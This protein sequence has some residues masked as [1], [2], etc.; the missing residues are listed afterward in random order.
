[1]DKW[2]CSCGQ[3]NTSNFCSSCGKPKPEN[4]PTLDVTTTTPFDSSPIQPVGENTPMLRKWGSSVLMLIF[5]IATSVY[6]LFTVVTLFMNLHNIIVIG[7]SVVNILIG[8]LVCAGAWKIFANAKKQDLPLQSGGHRML[9][10]CFVY[11]EVILTL[12]LAM[13]ILASFMLVAASSVIEQYSGELLQ[14]LQESGMDTTIVENIMALGTTIF[15]VLLIVAIV[16]FVITIIAFTFIRKDMRD[17]IN[18]IDNPS[19]RGVSSLKGTVFMF[20][21]AALTLIV[22]I[23]NIVIHADVMSILT[24]LVQTALFVLGG[25]LLLNFNKTREA[26][27]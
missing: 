15:V 23:L 11:Y 12:A 20:I 6:T 3:E 24:S 14:A 22:F 18:M 19:L 9:R 7:S 8:A 10:G 16:I 17:M 21:F 5:A 25:I 27:K 13:L 4:E 1:M 2:I 26:L